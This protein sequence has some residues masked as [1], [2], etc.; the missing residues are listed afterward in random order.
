MAVVADII[1]AGNLFQK[2][3]NDDTGIGLNIARKVKI[4]VKSLVV[5]YG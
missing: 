4:G 1:G 3:E 5:E 2:E